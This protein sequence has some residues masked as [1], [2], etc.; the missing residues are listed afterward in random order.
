[1]ETLRNVHDGFPIT[2][3][4][5]KERKRWMR[6]ISRDN[7]PDP[8][9][10]VICALQWLPGFRTVKSKGQERPADPSNVSQNISASLISSAIPKGLMIINQHK[11]SVVHIDWWNTFVPSSSSSF[12]ISLRLKVPLSFLERQTDA[13]WPILWMWALHSTLHCENAISQTDVF[14][15]HIENSTVCRTN[16]SFFWRQYFSATFVLPVTLLHRWFVVH[17]SH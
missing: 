6:T 7:I 3:G 12:S 2:W 11:L 1:M 16:S 10:N 14:G 8:S 13:R 9:D 17:H 5:P 4:D 15:F